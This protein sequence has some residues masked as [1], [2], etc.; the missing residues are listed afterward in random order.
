[1]ELMLEEAMDLTVRVLTRH[2]VTDEYARMVGDH[3]IDAALCG[4][5]FASLPRLLAIVEHLR[6]KPRSGPI[7]VVHEDERSAVI[8]GGDT[9]GYVVSVIAIDKAIDIAKRNGIAVVGAR[10]TWFSGRLAYYVE[11]AARQHLIAFHSTNTTARVAPFG[12]IDRI[13]GT[14]P[15]AFAFPAG[16]EPLIIDFGTASTTWG[17]VLLRRETG[18]TLPDGWAVDSAG[19]PTRDPAAALAGAFL[20][21]GGHRGSGLSIVA[22]VLGI[23]SG[24]K[25]VVDEAADFGFF[26]LVMDPGLL[27]PVAD[28]ESRVSELKMRLKASRPMTGAEAVRLPGEGSLKRRTA[29]GPRGRITVADEVYSALQ[30]IVSRAD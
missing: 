29:T 14:N 26:F 18:G 15:L 13:L 6:S 9:I 23:L 25:V 3:L 10:N 28:F 22:Q 24:S 16:D 21:W 12:G 19:E 5:E 11:R 20:P 17:E 1:M 30:S 27:M 8:D 4:Y 7:R 2:G